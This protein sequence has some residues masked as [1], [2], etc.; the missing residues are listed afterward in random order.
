MV[1]S[2]A[3]TILFF[4]DDMLDGLTVFRI[5]TTLLELFCS[6]LFVDRVEAAGLQGFAF[7]QIWP[8]PEGLTFN[9]ERY[10]V[11]RAC[12]SWKPRNTTA[13]DIKGNTVVLR[14][15]LENKKPSKKEV[16]DAEEVLSYLT[17][18]LYNPNQES[19]ESYFGNVEGYEFV[20]YEARF[21]LSAP[22][23]DRLITHLMPTLRTLPWP[24][25]FHVVKRR[26][27]F[28]DQTAREEYVQLT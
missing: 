6:Q 16:A 2:Q 27:E 25:K 20:D 22:D 7:M 15:Y 19:P 24:G 4:L 10:R 5:R 1:S 14:L 13:L 12:G 26:A 28:V 8:L 21:F 23:C 11:N 9:E 18:A 17:T 3:Q